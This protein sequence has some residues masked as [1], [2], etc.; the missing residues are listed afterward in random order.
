MLFG[1]DSFVILKYLGMEMVYRT[2]PFM[3]GVMALV[4]S[5]ALI[6]ASRGRGREDKKDLPA[7]EEESKTPVSTGDSNL[8]K[9]GT[10]MHELVSGKAKGSIYTFEVKEGIP[11]RQKVEPSDKKAEE[12]FAMI[13][14]ASTKR[15]TSRLQEFGYKTFLYYAGETGARKPDTEIIVFAREI[16]L[17][18]IVV[19]K[20]VQATRNLTGSFRHSTANE[21]EIFM[22][23]KVAE[24]GKTGVEIV[25]RSYG[26]TDIKDVSRLIKSGFSDITVEAGE[27]IYFYDGQGEPATGHSDVKN[28]IRLVARIMVDDGELIKG[29][30]VVA[31]NIEDNTQRENLTDEEM[32]EEIDRI[33]ALGTEMIDI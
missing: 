31:E 1:V 19:G 25:A 17:E 29:S 5:K 9:A 10:M 23:R 18:N 7:S 30:A 22:Y 26:E 20:L 33:I 16:G 15:D 14:E 2:A 11:P 13:E 27:K 6:A 4:V 28:G 24:E 21:L 3:G 32:F 12:A 8:K